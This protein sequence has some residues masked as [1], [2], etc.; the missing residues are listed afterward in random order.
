MDGLTDEWKQFSIRLKDFSDLQDWTNVKEFVIVLS[1][2]AVTRKY[3][4]FYLDDIY[5]A[6][7]PEQNFDMPEGAAWAT[8]AVR[9]H[10]VDGAIKEWP[11][12]AWH[13][14]SGAVHVESGARKNKNDASARWAAAWDNQWLYLAVALKD[15]ELVNDY[16]GDG[17][18]KGD[19]LEVYINPGSQDFSW[20]DPA[21]FQLGFSPTSSAG[22][23]AR[24]AWFQ[25]HAPTDAETQVAWNEA[26]T[27]MEVAVAWSFLGMRPTSGEGMGFSVSFHDVDVNDGTPECKLT[28][29]FSG[30]GTNRV[31]VGRL[32]LK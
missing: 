22:N 32:V 25:R 3:G 12:K 4:T 30:T 21:A 24:W 1:A 2:D 26:R 19:C 16:L 13:D 7:N 23:P 5:F 18:W 11:R 8:P 15:N 29:S 6:E 10:V 31:R 14:I 20:G 9:P 28:W 27:V 17:L